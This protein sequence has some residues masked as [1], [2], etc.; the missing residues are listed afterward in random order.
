MK[1]RRARG[2]KANTTDGKQG[3]RSAREEESG[4]LQRG[5]RERFPWCCAAVS[6]V[7]FT[8]ETPLS[9]ER[10]KSVER[11]DKMTRF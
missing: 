8:S 1:V 9:T 5:K 4:P 11:Q 3:L 2:G 10:V 6:C 7:L